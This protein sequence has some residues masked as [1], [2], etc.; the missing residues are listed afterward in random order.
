MRLWSL[1]PKYL[2]SKGL[3]AVWREGLLAKKVLE[4]KTKGYKNHPQLIRFKNFEKPLAAI[5][6]YL[7]YIFLESQYRGYSFDKSK[8]KRIELRNIVT[9]TKGQLKFELEHLLKKL[10]IRDPE[11][12][13][14]IK[15]LNII[16]IETNPIFKVIEGKIE[17]WEKV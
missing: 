5:N 9:V 7:Y 11:K 2:D 17:H 6:S 14:E 12:F 1:N 8:I 4:G 15:K 10:N 13:N 3:L 16:N